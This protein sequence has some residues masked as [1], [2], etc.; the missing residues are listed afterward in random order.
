MPLYEY[1]CRDC[2]SQF[3]LLVR[4]KDVP[5]CPQCDSEQLERLL[6]V[7]AAHAKKSAE[8]PLCERPVPGGC[9]LPQCGMGGCAME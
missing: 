1:A 6:S 8:L 7:P 4:G 3:E 2:D 9:G 5:H